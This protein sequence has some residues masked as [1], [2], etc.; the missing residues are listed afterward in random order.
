MICPKCMVQMHQS[1]KVGGGRADDESYV[2]W[3]LKK[4]PA[5]GR[6]VVEFYN[7][8][9]IRDKEHLAEIMAHLLSEGAGSN[10]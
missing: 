3:E 2:T 8:T 5:C 6:E 9:V 1:G 4:C 10:Q 7:A